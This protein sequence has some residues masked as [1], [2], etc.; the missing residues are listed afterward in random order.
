MTSYYSGILLIQHSRDQTGARLWNIPH[1]LTV[2][3]LT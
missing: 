1:Y 3:V 2:H